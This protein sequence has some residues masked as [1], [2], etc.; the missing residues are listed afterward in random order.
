MKKIFIALLSGIAISGSSQN[1]LVLSD[2]QV[3]QAGGYLVVKN[4]NFTNNCTFQASEGTVLIT[5]DA[6]NADAAIGGSSAS[7][8]YNL[9]IDKIVNNAELGN[10]IQVDNQ[11]TLTNGNIDLLSHDLTIASGGSISG[12]SA[13]AYITTSGTGSLIQEVSN[14]DVIFPVG[15]STCAPLTINNSGATDIFSVRVIDAV[16]LGGDSGTVVNTDVVDASWFVDEANPGGSDL[17]LTFQWNSSEELTDFDRTNAFVTQYT[18]GAWG[19]LSPQAATGSNPYS[20][21]ENG[22][23]TVSIFTVASDAAV[24]P[25]ELLYFYGEKT[26]ANVQLYWQTASE[27]NNAYFDVEWSVDGN[28][29]Q[30]I[31]QIA[32][33]GT[34]SE[35]QFYDFLHTRPSSGNNYYR[36]K[37]VNFDGKFEYSNLVVIEFQTTKSDFQIYP[38]PASDYISIDQVK[39]GELAQIFNAHGQLIEAFQIQG[40]SI[41]YSVSHFPEGAYFIKISNTVKRVM[42][43]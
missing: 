31:G 33:A 4:T 8:F 10:S 6:Y 12:G 29:F 38:N 28:D 36:L 30:K 22:I 25:V 19:N 32:G 17:A 14:S 9:E 11:L 5:G 39:E 24:L 2:N 21:S 26:G 37:Q 41:Q 15:F 27:I 18:N 42:I 3:K 35:T 34:T 40:L 1:H 13:A 7:A 43:Q 23:P 16:Y 20:L